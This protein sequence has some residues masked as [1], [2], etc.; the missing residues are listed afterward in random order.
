MAKQAKTIEPVMVSTKV[1]G[2]E[3]SVALFNTALEQAPHV[4]RTIASN[5]YNNIYSP[6]T[7][8]RDSFDRWDYDL[9]RQGERIPEDDKGK[10]L[11]CMNIYEESGFG[12]VKNIIDLMAELTVQGID[13]VHKKKKN[14]KFA[15]AWFHKTVK[16]PEFSERFTNLL[17]RCGNNFV[18]RDTNKISLSKV[19]KYYKGTNEHNSG[20]IDHTDKPYKQEVEVERRTI[21]VRYSLLNPAFIDVYSPE[22][23]R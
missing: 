2:E 11:A 3:K 4:L 7:S 19:R 9:L 17:C 14:E 20:T 18:K 21:P 10:I 23:T 12:I 22:L 5:I 6:N 13:V 15:K 8:V 16:G 1:D